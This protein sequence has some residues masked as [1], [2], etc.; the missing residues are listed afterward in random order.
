MTEVNQSFDDSRCI[1]AIDSGGSNIRATIFNKRGNI[2]AAESEQTLALHPEHGAT[3]YDPVLLWQAF[4]SVV[5]RLVQ[6]H[7][8]SAD[9]VEAMAIA[10]QRA[11]FCLWEKSTGK[12]VT[13]IISWQDVRAADIA[14]SMNRNLV[15]RGLKA[16]ALFI[17]LITRSAFFTTVSM[18]KITTDHDTCRLKWLFSRDRELWK[19][20]K[21]GEILFGTLDTWFIYNLTGGHLHVTD[22]TNAAATALFNPFG[23]KWNRI[24][25]TVFSIPMQ[26]LPRVL[27]TDG[28]FGKTESSYFGKAIPIRAAVGD[29]QAA[30]FG[31]CCFNAGEVKI[32]QGSG[33]FVNIN[34]GP[35]EKLSRRGLFPLL[36]WVSSGKPTYM[37]EGYVAT[38]GT[39]IDW[40]G[41]GMGIEDAP[42][43][44]NEYASQC[45]DSEG[46]IFIP[47]PSGIRFP[48]FNPRMKASILGL[49]LS[50]HR[51]HLARAVL[52]GMALRMLDIVE[53]IE[54]DTKVAILTIKVDGGVSRSDILLQCLADFSGIRVHRSREP[55]MTSRGAASLAGL[56]SGFWESREELR[57]LYSA[58]DTFEPRMS[59]IDR[60]AKIRTWKKAVRSVLNIE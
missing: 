45:K 26:I 25:C 43:A 2:V 38:A 19:R 12:A 36:A 57:S 35:K 24:F 28:D 44:L 32:S 14:D 16:A 37:L 27:E 48:F 53:G 41:R 34:V 42:Q 47:T 7:L 40:L 30:L 55:E 10:T 8:G 49:T 18:L 59:K 23:L 11:S 1:L 17:S 60:E 51:R 54:R 3:E 5:N 15:W 6:K 52:E 31:H 58:Y 33:A 21:N 4:V 13:K 29:Q 20:C 46:V 39:L 22:Y 56:G 9:L 50:T